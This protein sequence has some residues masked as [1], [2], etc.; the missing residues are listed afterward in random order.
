[1][2][3]STS[4]CV[5]G[6]SRDDTARVWLVTLCL[7]EGRETPSRPRSVAGRCYDNNGWGWALLGARVDDSLECAYRACVARISSDS[8]CKLNAGQRS[9]GFAANF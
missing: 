1:V 2:L 6:A 3:D 9:E 8:V 4:R 7:G 5:V